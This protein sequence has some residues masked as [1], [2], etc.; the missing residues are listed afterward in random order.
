MNANSASASADRAAQEAR[1]QAILAG[2]A[3][4]VAPND[5]II[6]KRLVDPGVYVQAGTAIARLAVVD[7][8]RVQANVAQGDLAGLSVGAPLEFSSAGRTF[9]GSVTSLSPVVDAM[10]RTAAVEAVVENP[11]SAFVPGGFGRVV[12]HGKARSGGALHVP[13]AAL[14]GSGE[15]A[16]VW[17]EINGTAHRV[18]VTVDAD[19][20]TTAAVSSDELTAKTRVVLAGASLLE[21]GQAIVEAPRS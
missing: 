11:G 2:Y 10:T 20:G 9:H 5:G 14:V 17:A 13:S 16:A 8:L 6:V 3:R 4:I 12:I 21:E 15:N 7:R 19:D 18:A 1:T